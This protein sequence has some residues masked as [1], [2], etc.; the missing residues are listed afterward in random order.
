MN[1]H[2]GSRIVSHD[3][4]DCF[5]PVGPRVRTH[6][7][8]LNIHGR[9]MPKPGIAFSPSSILSSVKDTPSGIL[10]NK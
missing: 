3:I 8:A 7:Q 4:C 1:A 2:E 9:I 5:E 6:P 10:I